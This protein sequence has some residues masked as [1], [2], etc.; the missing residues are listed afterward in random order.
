MD[1]CMETED[2]NTGVLDR[3]HIILIYYGTEPFI[4]LY[5]LY[6]V[7]KEELPR[8]FVNTRLGVC[9]KDLLVMW[10]HM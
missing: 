3:I 9:L 6:Y 5:K 7:R 10:K 4:N 2:W 8:V 1:L